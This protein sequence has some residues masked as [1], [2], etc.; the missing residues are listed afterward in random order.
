MSL[1]LLDAVSE[2]KIRHRPAES[3]L[4]RI[5]IHSGPVCAGVVG[6]KM[7]RYCL[8]GDT[9]NTASR[10]EST[11]LPLR[12]HCSAECKQMLDELGGYFYEDRGLISMKG[13]GEQRTFWLVGE[14]E[15][16]KIRRTKE[17]TE[18]RGS[19][20]HNKL[21]NHQNSFKLFDS[22]GPSLPRSSLKSRNMK[23]RPSIPRSS[24][25][26]SPKR[27]RFASGSNLFE[28]HRYNRYNSEDALMEVV[29][30]G[31]SPKKS[32]NGS[33]SEDFTSSC[34]CIE[35]LC[36]DTVS[37]TYAKLKTALP[38]E[39]NNNNNSNSNNNNGNSF[40]LTTVVTPL[41]AAHNR[42]L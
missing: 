31:A 5:G 21:F 15:D 22:N 4:L 26:E 19:R 42:H 37:A 30:D 38:C 1:H 8:F 41:L 40:Q 25:L 24:S 27:L 2:F 32:Q 36:P 39:T 3:L 20:T 14:D 16:S 34:P 12:I 28:H 11:G 7:P 13:K 23:Q 33:I 18:R 6:L 10:M 29:L 9:V 35:N 17:R